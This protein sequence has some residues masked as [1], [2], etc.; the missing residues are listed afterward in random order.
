MARRGATALHGA[1]VAA[2]LL[3]AVAPALGGCP[4][5]G[6]SGMAKPAGPRVS[7]ADQAELEARAR[8]LLEA[9]DED[10][11]ARHSAGDGGKQPAGGPGST[12]PARGRALASADGDAEH[13]AFSDV[14][15]ELLL[16][17]LDEAHAEAAAKLDAKLTLVAASPPMRH[18]LKVGH[19]GVP[20]GA[21]SGGARR[22]EHWPVPGPLA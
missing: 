19:S 18:A 7:P 20:G 22:G 16:G 10:M 17:S 6:T 12:A 21:G 15:A 4:F 5:A 9:V 11:S 14:A 13:A 2:L 1:L 3:C 8:R